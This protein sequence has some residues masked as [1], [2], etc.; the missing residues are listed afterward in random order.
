MSESVRSIT[1]SY[2]FCKYASSERI[3]AVLYE[4]GNGTLRAKKPSALSGLFEFLVVQ[5]FI[6]SAI[7]YEVDMEFSRMF[8]PLFGEDSAACLVGRRGDG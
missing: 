3:I 4:S 2:L 7:R 5:T 8:T 1:A 6:G